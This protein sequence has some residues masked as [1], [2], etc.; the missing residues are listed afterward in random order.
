MVFGMQE[1][2][3]GLSNVRNLLQCDE[4]ND[5]IIRAFRIG[6]RAT[7][8]IRPLKVELNFIHDRSWVIKAC[9]VPN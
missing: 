3:N 6:Q 4:Y 2:E 1:S 8:K 7:G 5:C 9:E